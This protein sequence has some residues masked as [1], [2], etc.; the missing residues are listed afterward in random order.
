MW[1]LCVGVGREGLPGRIHVYVPEGLGKT[2]VDGRGL[3]P[4]IW[5]LLPI[6]TV[7]EMR[8][9]CYF[10]ERCNR[11]EE[12]IHVLLLC[13]WNPLGRRTKHGRRRDWKLGQG[14]KGP[15]CVTLCLLWRGGWRTRDLSF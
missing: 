9:A 3:T 12:D 10:G 11:G 13:C 2:K 4:G 14:V 15:V 1:V 6:V 8:E 7:M 5:L